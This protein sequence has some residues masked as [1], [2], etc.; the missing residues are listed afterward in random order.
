MTLLR[1]VNE[2]RRHISGLDSFH[3]MPYHCTSICK[4]R[5]AN[6]CM[7][8]H[9]SLFVLELLYAIEGLPDVAVESSA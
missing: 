6:L 5:R 1:H 4:D 9:T 8:G 7:Q 3:L 2:L